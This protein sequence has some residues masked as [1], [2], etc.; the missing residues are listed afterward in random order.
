MISPIDHDSQGSGERREVV[1][2]KLRFLHCHET[3]ALVASKQPMEVL[4][5]T[6]WLPG[7]WWRACCWNASAGVNGWWDNDEWD[8]SRILKLRYVSTIFWATFCGDIPKHIVLKHR[9]FIFIWWVPPFWVP[10]M[11][12]E[13]M[14]QYWDKNDHPPVWSCLEI[15][16]GKLG[17]W[18]LWGAI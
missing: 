3:C 2:Y 11:A 17:I 16:H 12:I 8:I 4:C 7:L 15:N 6:S 9:P 18:M 14:G 5:S 10:E 1:N 13:M